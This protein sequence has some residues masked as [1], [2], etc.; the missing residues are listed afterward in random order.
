MIKTAKQL[1]DLTN[2][3][4]KKESL[5]P[6]RVFRTYLMERFLERISLSNYSDRFILKGGFLIQSM[7][8]MKERG[9]MD[10]DTTV[11]ALP[12]TEAGMM[13]VLKEICDMDI[14]D[15]IRFEIKKVDNIMEERDYPGLRIHLNGYLDKT[16]IPMK[17]DIST[18]DIITPEQITYDYKLLFENR[19]I[20]IMAYP[21]ETVYAEKLHS[22]LSKQDANTRMRDFYDIYI[23]HESQFYDRSTLMK[24][25]KATASKRGD[26][27]AICDYKS[28]LSK[29][30]DSEVMQK[31]WSEYQA[32]NTYAQNIEWDDIIDRVVDLAD[33]SLKDAKRSL[34]SNEVRFAMF[35]N[36]DL[37]HEPKHFKQ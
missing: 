19:S 34:N 18:G 29:I 28:I 2:N 6:Q 26:W 5:D 11:K 7:V 10:I 17:L 22:I 8:G 36:G 12:V 25:I 13:D 14:G 9:T 23:L 31:H 32:D 3:L 37:G 24:A 21:I 33:I 30:R 16:R 27:P 15:N 20:H 1:K 35:S 4:S